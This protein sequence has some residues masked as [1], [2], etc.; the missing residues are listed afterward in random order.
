MERKMAHNLSRGEQRSKDVEPGQV[1]TFA[2]LRLSPKLLR[3]LKRH[4]FV[5]P[6]KIQAAAIP[7]ALSDMDLLV[8]SKSGTGKTLIYVIAAMQGYRGGM[9]RPHAL[10]VVPTREL[11][12]QVQDT[13]FYLC[14]FFKDFQSAACIGGTDVST[15]R[16]HIKKSRVIIGTPGRLWHLYQNRVLDVSKLALLVL[17]EAD[18]L[19]QTKSLQET[20]TQ[21]IQVLPKNRQII[22]CSATYDQ[23]LDERLAKIMN[24][25]MLISNSERATVLLGIRQF[26]YELP[27]QRNSAEEMKAKLQVL[28]Q[29]FNQLPYEQ[30][31]LFANSQMRADSYSNYLTASGVECHLI[32]G[33][34]KQSERLNAFEGY[35]NF[36]M[37]TLVV[38]DLM[39]RG[40]DSQFANLVVNLDPP[41]S[42]V[43]YLHRIGRA[44]RFGS[45]GIAITLIASAKES[46]RFKEMTRKVATAWSV[47]E[48]PKEQMPKDFSFWDF[49]KYNFEYFIKE[50]NPLQEMPTKR[51]PPI[52]DNPNNE[53]SG[54]D[55]DKPDVSPKKLPEALG[56]CQKKEDAIKTTQVSPK[57]ISEALENV[58]DN[59]QK[60]KP[61]TISNKEKLDLEN[62]PSTSQKNKK[63]NIKELKQ[64]EKKIIKNKSISPTEE[65]ALKD[66]ALN[67]Q[68]K[69]NKTLSPSK[70]FV[71]AL[72][73]IEK[74]TT[75]NIEMQLTPVITVNEYYIDNYLDEGIKPTDDKENQPDN[76]TDSQL[77][78]NNTLNPEE[79]ISPELTPTLTQEPSPT[80]VTPPA[81]PVNSINNK[82]YCLAA[83]TQTS[84]MTI[85]N[86]VISNT[87]DDAS[88][89]SS[90]SM[91]CGYHSDKSY[92]TFYTTSD[93]ELIWERLETKKKRLVKRGKGNR[94]LF[95]YKKALP[96]RNVNLKDKRKFKLKKMVEQNK[97]SLLP[98]TNLSHM[99]K[100]VKNRERVLQM[101]YDY[102][103]KNNLNNANVAKLLD[104]F[105]ATMLELYNDN[106]K[107][108]NKQVLESLKDDLVSLGRTP[109][110]VSLIFEKLE[111]QNKLSVHVTHQMNIPPVPQAANDIRIE[112]EPESESTDEYDE[113]EEVYM[114]EE[115]SL[116]DEHNSSSGFV[117]SNESASSGID[118]SVYETESTGRSDND[119]T[120][121]FTEDESGSEEDDSYD[122][123][124]EEDES[125]EEEEA[126]S[127]I[128]V[129]GSSIQGSV[130]E[131]NTAEPSVDDSNDNSDD[132]SVTVTNVIPV[133]NVTNNAQSLW[134]Q[135]FN[136]QYEFIASHVA[137]YLQNFF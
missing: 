2:E 103:K 61:N 59:N 32:S 14:E 105:Y 115:E 4:N 64:V 56:N 99:L 122:S 55:L 113:G 93:E 37:R 114:D 86:M 8:Q 81:P 1:K 97:L 9:T 15:D 90:D 63:P 58:K 10:I 94:R 72:T 17:D 54:E 95:L 127:N 128:S 57:N 85:Q 70:L 3:G 43:T 21:I 73:Q 50:D 106:I 51:I 52:K 66:T 100:K 133:Q 80:T 132:D 31:V 92:D 68:E 27:P 44:G 7:M 71:D 65:K 45:K 129:A 79:M 24:N 76:G 19:Y 34:M 104:N 98:G 30:A 74:Q 121:V 16:R 78:T 109:S 28:G 137:N 53:D 126:L 13:F 75:E 134:Q 41:D 135:T 48:F 46:Q 12:I 82:T 123:T 131:G 29:I 124:E 111:P 25:P 35:R 77:Q 69:S 87:V 120:S 18:Q 91:G 40:V 67:K 60:D 33:A 101:L 116:S 36:T 130:G 112:S 119:S 110:Q 11:A 39:A 23:D 6:T 49:D 107:E 22:A 5:T 108:R 84:S 88:S 42:H 102:S 38:T 96:E 117:E 89:I 62:L 125:A 47:L 26:V 83:P 118:T 20:V 136:M